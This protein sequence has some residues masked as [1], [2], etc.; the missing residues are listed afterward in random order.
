MARYKLLSAAV[1][2]GALR[3]SGEEIE[4]DG[5]PGRHM[6]PLDKAAKD[7]VKEMPGPAPLD[8]E[9]LAY[10]HDRSI[11]GDPGIF[12]G[13]YGFAAGSPPE[14][15]DVPY[16]SGVGTVGEEL[17]CT[18]GNWNN[19]DEGTYAYQWMGNGITVST[20]GPQYVIAATDAGKDITCMVTATNVWGSTQAPPSNA[21]AVNGSTSTRRT[22]GGRG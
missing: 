11:P 17:S 15:V 22:G 19:M 7:A 8:P 18:M 9:Y 3:D 21:V 5:I 13:F 4:F 2:D 20:E 10:R 12:T 1:I 6:E 16:V 14:N